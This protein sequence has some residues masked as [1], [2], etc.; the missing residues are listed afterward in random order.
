MTHIDLLMACDITTLLHVPIN[1]RRVS[2]DTVLFT[3]SH[4][5]TYSSL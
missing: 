4:I 3:V 1:Q 2:L 5:S